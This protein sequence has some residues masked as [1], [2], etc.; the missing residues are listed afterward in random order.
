MWGLEIYP[1]GT[2]A[3]AAAGGVGG[4]GD[5]NCDDDETFGST[6][7]ACSGAQCSSDNSTSF[8][9]HRGLDLSDDSPSRP[10]LVR[11]KSVGSDLVRSHIEV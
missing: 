9:M 3:A 8:S 2:F 10:R 7:D 5:D 1:A 6:E 4:T 11:S